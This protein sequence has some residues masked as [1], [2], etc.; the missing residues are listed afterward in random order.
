VAAPHWSSA[1]THGDALVR[2]DGAR[3][4]VR[5]RH[6][7][8]TSAGI[9]IQVHFIARIQHLRAPSASAI[10]VSSLRSTTGRMKMI[11]SLRCLLF[12]WPLKI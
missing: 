2:G 1:L 7:R 12:V 3:A 4:G 8:L 6:I 9:A 10:A 11:N 5:S